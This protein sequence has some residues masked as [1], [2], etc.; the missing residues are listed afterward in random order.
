MQ[1]DRM[2]SRIYVRP[3]DNAGA[4]AAL[5]NA[6]I[7]TIDYKGTGRGR[8]FTRRDA[9]NAARSLCHDLHARREDAEL[10]VLDAYGLIDSI[11]TL[12]VV[13]G[14]SAAA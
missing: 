4:D 8:Y 7:W 3:I 6:F 12:N 14:Q 1:N 5:R 13:D 9:V 10:I 2:L 11:E